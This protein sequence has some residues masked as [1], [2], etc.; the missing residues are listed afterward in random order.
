MQV[1]DLE[2]NILDIL[3]SESWAL[4]ELN[5]SDTLSN[6]NQQHANSEQLRS[7]G[8]G[9]RILKIEII[10]INSLNYQHKTFSSI[11]LNSLKLFAT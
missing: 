7:F 4:A 5:W 3:N 2:G 9:I 8:K 1:V 6:L 11:S 10:K